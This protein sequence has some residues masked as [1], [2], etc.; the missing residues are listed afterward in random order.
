MKIICIGRN[1]SEHAKELKN[2]VPEEPVV[3]LKP[4][5][6]LLQNGKDFYLPDFSKD[7]HYECELVVKICRNGKHV[8]EKFAAKYYN[9][10][11]VGIDFTARDLQQK[12]KEKGLPWEVAKAFDGS[13]VAGA[14]VPLGDRNISNLHFTLKKNGQEVQQGH[15]ADMIFT[16]DKVIAYV[17]R[18][19]SLNTGDLIYTGTPSGVGSV[20]IGDMLEGFLEGEKLF[21]TNIK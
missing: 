1:Y 17:S 21:E 20:A 2:D 18:F 13:A 7:V 6:S 4:Q 12:Q 9:E 8:Q 19:F 3:F 10:I 14:F 11:T 5:S 16:I 15:S